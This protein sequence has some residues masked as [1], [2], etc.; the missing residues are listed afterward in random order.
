MIYQYWDYE[1][2]KFIPSN[3]KTEYFLIGFTELILS[4]GSQTI[5]ILENS[6]DRTISTAR[7]DYIKMID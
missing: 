7:I 1:N 4:F 2:E 6:K 5:A 3:D